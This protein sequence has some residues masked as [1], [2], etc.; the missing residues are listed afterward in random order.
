MDLNYVEKQE[1]GEDLEAD[2][3]WARSRIFDEAECKAIFD[4][5]KKALEKGEAKVDKISFKET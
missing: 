1:Q 3:S 2:F 4:Q 5:V